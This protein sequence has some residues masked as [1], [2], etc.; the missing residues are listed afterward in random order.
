MR[1]HRASTSR[2]RAPLAAFRITGFCF[3]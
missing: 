3:R 1:K 2:T